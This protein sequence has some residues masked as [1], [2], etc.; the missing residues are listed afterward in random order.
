MEIRSLVAILFMVQ[1]FLEKLSL[2]GDNKLNLTSI[3]LLSDSS[4]PHEMECV[5]LQLNN[6]RKNDAKFVLI[7]M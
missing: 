2:S 4:Y 5:Y 6:I 3:L 7:G 1:P